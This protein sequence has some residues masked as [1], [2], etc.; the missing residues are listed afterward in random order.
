MIRKAKAAKARSLLSL[1]GVIQPSGWIILLPA[2]MASASPALTWMPLTIGTGTTRLSHL[3]VPLALSA[4]TAMPIVK[5]AAIVSCLLK[6]WLIATAAMAFIG[7][8]GSG[9]P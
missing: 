9:I 6:F 4:K 7:C 8:T 2:L 5:P 1:P 3:R